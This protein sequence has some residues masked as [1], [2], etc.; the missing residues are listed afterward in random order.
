[1]PTSHQDQATISP[2]ARACS[3]SIAVSSP[4]ACGGEGRVGMGCSGLEITNTQLKGLKWAVSYSANCKSSV[5]FTQFRYSLNESKRFPHFVKI[6]FDSTMYSKVGCW[7]TQRI[8]EGFISSCSVL[9]P[10]RPVAQALQ[11]SF[12]LAHS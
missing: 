1:M 6:I 2:S 7:R 9:F 3:E 8:S 5:K 11:K 12:G 4:H 10:K